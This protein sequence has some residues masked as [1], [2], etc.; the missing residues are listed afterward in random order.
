[1]KCFL[2]KARL[3]PT[4]ANPEPQIYAMRIFAPTAVE[5]RSKF[6]YCWKRLCNLLGNIARK[7]GK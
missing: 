4:E 2:I 3:L 1:M 5:G 7:R 6:W